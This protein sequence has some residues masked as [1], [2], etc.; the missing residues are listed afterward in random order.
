MYKSDNNIKTKKVTSTADKDAASSVKSKRTAVDTNDSS[1]YLSE[2]MVAKM[3]IKE[4]EK[5]QD[6][7]MDAQ[8]NGKF[9]YD[10]SKR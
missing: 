8:R 4:Y 1:N 10:M 2:S 6:E 3:T 7:I 5:R 9:I